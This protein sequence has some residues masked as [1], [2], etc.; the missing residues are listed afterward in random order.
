M[1]KSE[2][3]DWL[4]P[5]TMALVIVVAASAATPAAAQSE[6]DRPVLTIAVQSDPVQDVLDP[7]RE[8]S[9]VGQRFMH[10]LFDSLLT[11]DYFDGWRIGPGLA[12]SWR[13]VDD[14]T[15][16][17]VLR[18][19][20]VFHDGSVMTADDVVFSLSPERILAEDWPGAGAMQRFW[21]GLE[22]VEALDDRTVRFTTT[23]VDPM[24]EFRVAAGGSQIISRAAFE[25]ADTVDA[26]SRTP[27][28][29]GPFRVA[30]YRPDE[31]VVYEAF[32]AYWGGAPSVAEVR[33]IVVPEV[34]ARI[35]GLIAGDFDIITNL[36]PDQLSQ[37]S[38]H[39]G[40]R[41]AGGPIGN[42]HILIFDTRH[43]DLDDPRMRRALSLAIDRRAIVDALWEGQTAIPNGY[44]FSAFGDLYHSDWP[45][46]EYDPE[47]A[48]TLVEEAGYS[49]Q[50]VPFNIVNNY[51]TTE[52]PRAEVLVD[53]WRDIGV[54]VDITIHD[55]F[56]NLNGGLRNGS[57]TIV[58]PDPVGS[59]CLTWSAG[60]Y[61]DRQ[62]VM[63]NVPGRDRFFEFCGD[64]ASTLDVE[65]RRRTFGEILGFF[66]TEMPMVVLHQ[67][68]M[69]YGLRDGID[70][71]PVESPIME[72]RAFN[73]QVGD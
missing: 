26:W 43:A 19:D 20:V 49:G 37:V 42:H 29:T 65:E 36:S 56:S 5:R 25:A 61:W 67:N 4:K 41:V 21:G 52:V 62:G 72:L 8:V 58:Y 73:L 34:A 10:N 40:F 7:H 54:D 28:G 70:W 31:I 55:D 18:D 15:F 68:A 39:E 16:E 45:E 33:W 47:A 64:L 12:Q 60:S 35:A 69:F 24:F 53:M 38:R 48:R 2:I 9:N 11:I 13:R 3:V 6:N 22:S 63:E 71:R 59:I 46:P 32:D 30:E 50:V 66:E 57:T 23:E 1:I 14:R 17:F 44:Q 27:I 51:Y